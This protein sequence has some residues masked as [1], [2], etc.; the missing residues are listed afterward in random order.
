METCWRTQLT[1]I[2]ANVW[3]NA[4]RQFM[5]NSDYHS[6][7]KWRIGYNMYWS[8]CVSAMA[9]EYNLTEHILFQG[10]FEFRVFS[11]I[12]A[13]NQGNLPS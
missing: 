4:K 13:A 8:H 11:P 10:G 5:V 12:L 3:Q 1:E 2:S 7:Y 9:R 6:R